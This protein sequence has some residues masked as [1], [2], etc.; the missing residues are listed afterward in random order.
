MC[1]WVFFLQNRGAE[2]FWTGAAGRVNLARVRVPVSWSAGPNKEVSGLGTG[3]PNL[4]HPANCRFVSAVHQTSLLHHM[5]S[6]IEKSGQIPYNTLLPASLSLV[7]LVPSAPQ[8]LRPALSQTSNMTASRNLVTQVAPVAPITST[9]P[10]ESKEIAKPAQTA[11]R[12]ALVFQTFLTP[13]IEHYF[14]FVHGEQ[15][16]TLT[17]FLEAFRTKHKLE[18]TRKFLDMQVTLDGMAVSIDLNDTDRDWDWE[19]AMGAFA[20]KGKVNKVIVRV[21]I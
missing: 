3:S 11:S 2:A 10:M 20:K 6:T 8:T 18:P 9:A 5:S 12:P 16:L 13:S 7:R 21:E 19:A 15:N 17:N 1:V 14:K 4:T